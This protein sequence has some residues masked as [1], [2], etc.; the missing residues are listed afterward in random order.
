MYKRSTQA[1]QT[2]T[3]TTTSFCRLS[4]MRC[5]HDACYANVYPKQHGFVTILPTWLSCIVPASA[6]CRSQQ[7]QPDHCP[8]AAPGSRFTA[9]ALMRRYDRA[10]VHRACQMQPGA[11]RL[12]S[13]R[14]VH[15]NCCLHACCPHAC[16]LPGAHH[17]PQGANSAPA[18]VYAR[19]L[20]SLNSTSRHQPHA[21]TR[22]WR[23]GLRARLHAGHGTTRHTRIPA[24]T[25]SHPTKYNGMP[26]T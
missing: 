17:A 21:H 25:A 18:N 24:G 26:G 13:T 12:P 20:N 2:Y 10:I 16:C 23:L 15:C 7:P 19:C 6:C 5:M 4:T 1:H 8:A 14:N 9:A 22:A 3:S 11:A